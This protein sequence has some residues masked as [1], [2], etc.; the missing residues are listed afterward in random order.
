MRREITNLEDFATSPGRNLSSRRLRPVSVSLAIAAQ[1]A[2]IYDPA[3][4]AAVL[5]LVNFAA[6]SQRVQLCWRAARY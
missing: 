5:W 4:R 3:T 6:N 1:A 2:R